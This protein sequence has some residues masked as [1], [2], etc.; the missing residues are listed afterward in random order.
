M[1]AALRWERGVIW[2]D[3]SDAERVSAHAWWIV[4]GRDGHKL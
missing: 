4:R 1:I 2:A 3:L